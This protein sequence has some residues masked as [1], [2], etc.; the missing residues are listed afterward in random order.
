MLKFE[1]LKKPDVNELLQPAPQ[2]LDESTGTIQ[3]PSKRMVM[4][5][6]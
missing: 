5:G 1:L 6:E 4:D 2:A 3:V